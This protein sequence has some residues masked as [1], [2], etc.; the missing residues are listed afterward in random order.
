MKHLNLDEAKD[1]TE[2]ENQLLKMETK[3]LLSEE[4]RKAVSIKALLHF[5]RSPLAQRIKESIQVKKEVPFILSL[6]AREIY[7]ELQSDEEVFVRGIIDCYFEEED[8]VVLIDYKTDAIFEKE[9]PEREIEQLMKKYEVQVNLYARAIEEI[10]GKKVKEKCLYLFSIV[11]AVF[12]KKEP[13][14]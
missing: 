7:K 13:S 8:G 1:Y 12:Y 6:S 9:N 11:K 2:I 10:T 4:E 3:G 14:S 5:S